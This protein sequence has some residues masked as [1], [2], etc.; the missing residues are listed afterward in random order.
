MPLRVLPWWLFVVGVAACGY[1][2]VRRAESER[3]HVVLKSTEVAD[4]VVT[5]SVLSG[6]RSALADE[7]ALAPGDGFPRL[8]VEVLRADETSEGIARAN[9][10]NGPLPVARGTEVGVVARAWV[11]PS[12]GAS[13]LR[14]TGDMRATDLLAT[15]GSAEAAIVSYSDG[16]RASATRLGRALGRRVLGNPSVSD[17][18][19]GR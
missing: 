11:I 19:V 12:K 5:D 2:S 15:P 7:G 14:D 17:D 18:P 16:L 8:E 9:S 1:S 3:L 10:P 6:V 4:A 13:A